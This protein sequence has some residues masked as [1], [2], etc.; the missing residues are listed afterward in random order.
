MTEKKNILELCPKM[1]G[2]AAE[3]CPKILGAPAPPLAAVLF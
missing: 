3:D 2:A 1:L